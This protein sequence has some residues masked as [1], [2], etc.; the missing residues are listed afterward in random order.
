MKI[1][2][3]DTLPEKIELY[4]LIVRVNFS[5]NYLK[6]NDSKVEQYIHSY[7]CE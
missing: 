3:V 6:L 1:V 5:Y 7:I 4:N 2:L